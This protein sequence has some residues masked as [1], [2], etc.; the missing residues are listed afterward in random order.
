DLDEPEKVGP[1]A[2]GPAVRAVGLVPGL[3]AVQTPRLRQPIE[4][5]LVGATEAR[6][7]PGA[8][9]GQ[10]AAADGNADQVAEE[11]P[12]GGARAG[13][14]ALEVGDQRRPVRAD[15]PGAVDRLGERGVMRGAATGAAA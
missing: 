5:L 13:A 2:P 8:Q 4:H 6:A 10:P 1:E 9:A 14:G 7:D 3:I 11:L 12:D 15:Q